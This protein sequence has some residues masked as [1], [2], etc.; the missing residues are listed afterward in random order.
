MAET[1]TNTGSVLLAFV[2]GAA[3]GALAVLLLAPKSGAETRALLADKAKEAKDVAARVPDA[4]RE[5][6]EAGR[7][8]F[9]DAMHG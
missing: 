6:G 4:V 3:A 2:A 7:R 8:A 9:T 1:N 5:A